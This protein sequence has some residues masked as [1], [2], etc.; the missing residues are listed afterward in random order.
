MSLTRFVDP[1]GRLY[2]YGESDL[3]SQNEMQY[4]IFI[5]ERKDEDGILREQV[6]IIEF[7]VKGQNLDK[8]GYARVWAILS[9]S[10]KIFDLLILFSSLQ[11]FQYIHTDSW[12]RV[13]ES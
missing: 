12:R 2:Y 10:C 8:E 9:L 11:R 3:K 13:R 1:R 4:K 5:K 7:W 6:L